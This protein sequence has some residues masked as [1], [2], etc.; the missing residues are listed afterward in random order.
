M[1]RPTEFKIFL[2][3]DDAFSLALYEQT[4]RS[5]GCSNIST[6]D[7][8]TNCLN[9]LIEK[10]QV[11]FLDHN[12]DHITGFEVLKKIKYF[13]EPLNFLQINHHYIVDILPNY[14]VPDNSSICDINADNTLIGYT[15]IGL[16]TEISENLLTED[17]NILIY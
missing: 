5:I 10:P 6:F 15:D 2:V 11:I 7:N 9:A 13:E 14:S 12:M 4:L 1:T 17:N 8:G 3:D 16:L